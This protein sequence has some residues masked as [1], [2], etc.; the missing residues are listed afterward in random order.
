MTKKYELELYDGHALIK[1]NDNVIL[2]D[3][4]SQVTFHTSSVLNFMGRNFDV[5]TSY[6]GIDV[7]SLSSM[8]G[9]P[10][11]TLLGMDIISRYEV[12]FDY[13]NKA[14][15]FSDETTGMDGEVVSISSFGGVPVV[16]VRIKNKTIKVVV[17]T[18]AK[19][20]Y[21]S[22]EF[23][24]G[25][26]PVGRV[27]DFYPL[28]GNFETDIYNLTTNIENESFDVKYGK[29]P[30]ML[31]KLLLTGGIHGILGYDLMSNFKVLLDIGSEKMILGK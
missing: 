17:D 5:G 16:N 11:T 27:Q 31:K 21:M 4:G 9:R 23:L 8:L 28:L 25:M 15:T 10:I 12:L 24:N 20:S 14:V 7:E 19:I 6:G 30:D 18:G 22:G 1:E 26:D 2:I 3:T 29:L 13:N